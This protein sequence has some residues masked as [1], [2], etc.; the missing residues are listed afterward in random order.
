MKHVIESEN[1][2]IKKVILIGEF[3][4]NLA[5]E[6][7]ENDTFY[8]IMSSYQFIPQ[9][10]KLTRFPTAIRESPSLLDHIWLNFSLNNFSGVIVLD[11]TG[12]FPIFLSLPTESNSNPNEK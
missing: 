2:N 11:F 4:R 1:L 5:N 12:H 3:Y 9:I 7:S 8:N 6:S 10:N